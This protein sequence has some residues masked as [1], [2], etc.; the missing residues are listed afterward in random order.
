MALTS[1]LLTA[2]SAVAIA[3]GAA[4][5]SYPE[6]PVKIIVA[7]QAGQGTDVATRHFAE[8]LTKAFKQT[9]YVENHAG[10]GGNINRPQVGDDDSMHLVVRDCIVA[11]RA[12]THLGWTL[13]P[14]LTP[15][16]TWECAATGY[17]S[18]TLRTDLTPVQE[19]E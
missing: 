18:W 6:R 19:R 4:A 17:E 2:L 16:R 15:V 1:K 3:T 9:F 13:L 11:T 7:Y 8:E 12:G 5:Q 10:A 14:D